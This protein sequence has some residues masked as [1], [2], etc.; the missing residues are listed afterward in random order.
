M[1][2]VTLLAQAIPDVPQPS[3]ETVARARA[4]LAALDDPVR[5]PRPLRRWAWTA[6]AGVATIAVVTAVIM[7]VSHLGGVPEPAPQPAAP[8][9]FQQAPRVHQGL[10][11]LAGARMPQSATKTTLRFRPTSE[12]IAIVLFCQ[13]PG[14]IFFSNEGGSSAGGTCGPDGAPSMLADKA[15]EPGWLGRDHEITF[16]VFPPD[17]PVA[18]GRKACPPQ[19]SC[20]GAYELPEPETADRLAAELGSRPG[21]WSVAAY[22]VQAAR[23]LHDIADRVEKL[24]ARTG[25]YWRRTLTNGSLIRVGAPGAVYRL[26]EEARFDWWQPRD[27]TGPLMTE[28]RRL[29]TRPATAA[30]ERAWRAAGSPAEVEQACMGGTPGEDCV[31]LKLSSEPSACEYTLGVDAKG[32]LPDRRFAGLTVAEVERLPADPARLRDRLRTLYDRRTG[33]SFEDALPMA[34]SLLNLPLKPGTRAALLHLL[35]DLPTTRVRGQATD[36]LGRP[37][38]RVSFWDGKGM[39]Y[40]GGEEVPTEFQQIL[41]P[42]TGRILAEVTVLLE[43]REGLPKGT[44]LHYTAHAS[45]DGW[46]DERPEEPAD[47]AKKR[48]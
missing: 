7:L 4:R 11:R 39:S 22:D 6:G 9:A 35:A 44:V 46:T 47:C 42:E 21:A 28:S 27:P 38:I 15:H 34:A 2:E 16:W 40:P 19:G 33:R 24:P 3:A 23:P 13:K 43:A 32:L 30:D 31:R 5:R 8:P 29:F 18:R 37:G 12:R 36:P 17:A 1:D 14:S 20:D 10:H 41:D 26:K 48:R 45:G 25:A